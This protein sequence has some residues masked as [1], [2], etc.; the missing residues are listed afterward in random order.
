MKSRLSS[1]ATESGGPGCG[2]LC[3]C[4]HQILMTNK[5]VIHCIHHALVERRTRKLD[6][7]IVFISFKPIWSEAACQTPV[8]VWLWKYNADSRPQSELG[9][10]RLRRGCFPLNHV[11]QQASSPEAAG[12]RRTRLDGL[13][14]RS[15]D[16]IQTRAGGGSQSCERAPAALGTFQTHCDP[17]GSLLSRPA[18]VCFIIHA[19]PAEAK[20]R[21]LNPSLFGALP[22]EPH[23]TPI[24]RG[25]AGSLTQLRQLAPSASPRARPPSPTRCF[26]SVERHRNSSPGE[27]SLQNS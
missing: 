8:P 13:G 3:S 2:A 19:T 17:D 20:Q 4:Q 16:K 14:K 27:Q 6:K 26:K 11:Y 25:R 5:T 21:F 18:G 12:S 10:G 9:Y 15:Q 24:E 7:I 23:V 1:L 22:A